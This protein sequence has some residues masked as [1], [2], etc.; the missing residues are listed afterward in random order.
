MRRMSTHTRNEPCKEPEL[1]LEN[2]GDQI[3]DFHE[4]RATIAATI[5][6]TKD[7]ATL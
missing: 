1:S 7:A 5:A 4:R 3:G 6:R 2:D